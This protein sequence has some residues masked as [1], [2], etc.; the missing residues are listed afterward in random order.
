MN[1]NITPTVIESKQDYLFSGNISDEQTEIDN[2]FKDL[3]ARATSSGDYSG[4]SSS[5]GGS[6]G[7][8][9]DSGSG[10]GS[11]SGGS[12]GGSSSGGSSG[13]GSSGGSSGGT[14]E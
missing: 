4:G 12:S 14:E 1:F 6:S 5:S 3:D 13:G 8:S 11:S 9:S 2:L 10:G 7:G